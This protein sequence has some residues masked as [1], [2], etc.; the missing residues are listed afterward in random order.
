MVILQADAEATTSVRAVCSVLAS[1]SKGSHVTPT[2]TQRS[3]ARN[4]PKP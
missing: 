3:E 1:L 2:P 4:E